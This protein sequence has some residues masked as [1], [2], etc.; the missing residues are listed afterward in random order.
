MAM[1][2]LNAPLRD[3][4]LRLVPPLEGM[5]VL[6]VGCGTGAQLER[7]QRAGCQISGLDSSP[8]MLRR[9]RARLGAGVDL[10]LA[11]AESLPYPDKEFDLILASLMLHELQPTV[12]DAVVV[13]INR[14]L[15]PN[16]RILVTDFHPGP[17]TVPKGWLYRGIGVVAEMI[18][19]HR[20][21]SAAFLAAGGIPALAARLGLS[22]ERT[23][24][25]AGGNMGL[26]VL[27]RTGVPR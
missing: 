5:R 19:R 10:Q 15:A 4:G 9:A 20:D 13:E 3:I 2:P 18:A 7:Y 22:I 27:T 8:A 16:G 21:R 23:K 24:V 17:W 12:R 6:D 11:S 25:L 1:E 26:Y 14:V